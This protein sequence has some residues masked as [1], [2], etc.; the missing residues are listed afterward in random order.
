M[1]ISESEF[2][3]IRNKTIAT[4]RKIEG[5]TVNGSNLTA[6]SGISS[7]LGLFETITGSFAVSSSLGLFQEITSSNSYLSNARI[8]A[9]NIY[10]TVESNIIPD[11]DHQYDLGI[12]NGSDIL[13]WDNAYIKKIVISSGGGID[14]GSSTAGI[15]SSVSSGLLDDYEEGTYTVVTGSDNAFPW[16]PA[17]STVYGHY[18]KIGNLVYV[19]IRIPTSNLDFAPG[20]WASLPFTAGSD[21][22]QLGY[23]TTYRTSMTAGGQEIIPGVILPSQSK[24]YIV[25]ENGVNGLDG[26]IITATYIAA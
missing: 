8:D 7:S 18:T 26:V 1:S 9:L 21:R 2:S 14:F 25:R 23:L 17:G 22:G 19:R 11:L 13:R 5:L 4:E 24:I 12:N 15:G 3:R 16:T 6:S 10:N 20:A